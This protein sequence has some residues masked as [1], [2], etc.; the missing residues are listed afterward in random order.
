[1]KDFTLKTKFLAVF[2]AIVFLLSGC[3]STTLIDSYPSGAFLYLNGEAVGQTPYEM[4]DTKP[5]FTCTSVRIE[6]DDHQPFYTTICRN[7]EADVGAIIAGMF[8]YVPFIWSMKYKPTHYYRL[9]PLDGKD[10]APSPFEQLI[11]E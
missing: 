1:M 5:M 6:K 7:E 9:R 3:A 11:N 8:F 4:T 10:N 2:L